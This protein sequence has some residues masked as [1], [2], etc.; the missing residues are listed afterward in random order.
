MDDKLT[1]KSHGDSTEDFGRSGKAC[2]Q[3]CLSDQNRLI[4]DH[5]IL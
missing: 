3:I 5:V 4:D 2:G 1:Y